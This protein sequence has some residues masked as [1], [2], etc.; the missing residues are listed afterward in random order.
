MLNDNAFET[1]TPKVTLALVTFIEPAGET[2]FDLSDI[3]GEV[4]EAITPVDLNRPG[5]SEGSIV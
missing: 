1:I 3:A 5:F 4:G 2:L